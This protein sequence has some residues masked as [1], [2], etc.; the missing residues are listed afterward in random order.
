MRDLLIKL[1]DAL[2]D[3]DDSNPLLREIDDALA[4]LKKPV[5]GPVAYILKGQ[6][7]TGDIADYLS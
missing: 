4:E 3:F 2:Y 1:A 5:P 7:M 6:T